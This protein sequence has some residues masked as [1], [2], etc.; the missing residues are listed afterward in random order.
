MQRGGARQQI[1]RL[2]NEP[3]L[4]IADPR[5]FIVGHI[6]DQVAVEIVLALRRRIQAADQIHQRRLARPGRTHD[7]DIFAAL[8]LDVD[9]RDRVD[10][11]VAH[12]VGLPEIVG[13]DDDAVAL[14]LLAAFD[15]F[16]GLPMPLCHSDR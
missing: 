11:L 9:A 15:Q 13:A 8:D 6:A 4:L 5:Q 7:R 2:K 10:L 12:D 16:L 1:E 3:D 14:E